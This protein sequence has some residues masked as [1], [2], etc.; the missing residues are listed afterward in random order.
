[1]TVKMQGNFFK[2]KTTW[3]GRKKKKKKKNNQV[4]IYAWP[5][6]Y[7]N[8]ARLI[9]STHRANFLSYKPNPIDHCSPLGQHKQGQIRKFKNPLLLPPF[10][11][12]NSKQFHFQPCFF[13]ILQWPPLV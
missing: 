11:K 12:S 9:L 7:T 4:Q 5:N 10:L 8:E 6:K 13:D 1:M 3:P 2:I